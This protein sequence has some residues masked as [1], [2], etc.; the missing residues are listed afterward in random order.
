M[1]GFVFRLIAPRPGFT[2]E[3]SAAERATMI[4][5]IGYW[6]ALTAAGKVLAFGP[7][8]DPAGAYGIGIIVVGSLAEAEELRAGDPAVRS[9]HGFRSEIAPMPRLVTPT[10]TYDAA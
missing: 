7:V 2:T 3:M 8:D 5:H 4:D 1:P 6:S 9:A 10:A